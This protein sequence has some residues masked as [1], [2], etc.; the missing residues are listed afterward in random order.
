MPNK[1]YKLGDKFNHLTIIDSATK[2]IG[3][4]GRIINTVICKC[5]CGKTSETTISKLR[6][7]HTKSCGLNT[8]KFKPQIKHNMCKS[9]TYNSWQGM[10]DR[11][12]NNN[13]PRYK[14]YKGRG[15]T[16]Q[17]DW[18][19]FRNFLRD[20]GEKPLGRS[21]DRIDNNGNYCKENCR[22]ATPI[23]QSNNLRTNRLIKYN[24]IT[25]TLPEWS[26]LLSINNSALSARY[27]RGWT[28]KRMLETK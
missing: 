19:D 2:N 17:D 25:R 13:N 7:G 8:C 1:S 3:T 21:L 4:Q 5:D 26:R 28:P 22:W 16:Y 15:I 10:L 6:S 18:S 23:E 20:M 27:S 12:K 14:D 24:G 9:R 11:C